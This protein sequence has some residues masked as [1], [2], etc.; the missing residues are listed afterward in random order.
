MSEPMSENT[1]WREA[2]LARVA[3][4]SL[5][6]EQEAQ[7]R[8]EIAADP[9]LSAALDDQERAVAMLR[10]ADVPAPAALRAAVAEQLQT[11]DRR[12]RSRPRPRPRLR[13]AFPAVAT[14]AIAAAV[15]IV[16]LSGAGT[17]SPTLRQTVGLTLAASVSPP[18]AERGAHSSALAISSAGIP[19]PYWQQTVGWRALGSR[20]DRIDQRTIVTVFY[21]GR[22][23]RRV[24]YAIVG[25]E[26]LRA[27]G[28]H[29]VTRGG[30]GYRLTSVDGVPLV[31]WLRAGHTCVIA[32]RG[33][34]P[35]TLLALATADPRP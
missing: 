24:G 16:L 14:V 33:V 21:R 30:V 18:P 20:T 26:P 19:F 23:G 4:G 12:H 7:R 2:E 17:P 5:T 1:P 3:D 29:V 10:A 15:V 6:P 11:A 8:R 9:E 35:A 34:A 22:G 28:G 31:T 25:G 13:L 27:G 32:G